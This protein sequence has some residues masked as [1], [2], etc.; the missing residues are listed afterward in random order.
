MGNNLNSSNKLMFKDNNIQGGGVS[1]GGPSQ[2]IILLN[3][4]WF[5]NNYAL[6]FLKM[7]IGYLTI[8]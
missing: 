6:K 4:A 1:L 7:L 3:I 2:K 5:V 8:K